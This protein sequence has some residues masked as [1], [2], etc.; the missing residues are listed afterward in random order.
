MNDDNIFTSR[1]MITVNFFSAWVWY[2]IAEE[3]ENSELK[4]YPKF[5]YY[6]FYNSSLRSAIGWLKEYQRLKT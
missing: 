2:I 4:V 6:A 1:Y 3:Y 5:D